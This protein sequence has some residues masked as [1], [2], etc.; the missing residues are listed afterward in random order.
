MNEQQLAEHRLTA[1]TNVT[2]AAERMRDTMERM[3]SDLSRSLK[4]MD[5]AEVPSGIHM[6]FGPVGHQAPFDLATD[7]AKLRMTFEI[8]RTLGCSTEDIE[9]AYKV[10]AMSRD[11]R[12]D[13]Y[14]ADRADLENEKARIWQE[15]YSAGAVDEAE[16]TADGMPF[17]PRPNPYK[18]S[19]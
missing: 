11:A 5:N 10:G 6:G 19:K 3:H 1:L 9:N 15:A 2:A 16:S 13:Y 8:A 7:S 14:C 18:S 4:Q 17:L 12:L